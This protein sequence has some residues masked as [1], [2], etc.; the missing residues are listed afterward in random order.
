MTRGEKASHDPLEAS[1]FGGPGWSPRPTSLRQ[2]MGTIWHR[3]GLDSESAP[4]RSVLL[5]CPGDELRGI[6]DPDAVQW[7]AP[8]KAELARTQHDHMAA[9]YRDAGIAVHYVEPGEL[10]PPN[11]M[12]VADLMFMTPEGAIVGRPASTVRARE[13]RFLAR[14]L[15][16]LGVPIL[17]TVHGSGCFEGADA[18]WLDPST[19][20]IAT[21]LRTNAEGAAQ[22]AATLREL[23]VDAIIVGLPHGTM[24]MMGIL[25]F[26]D[27]NLAIAWPGRVPWA[28][29]GAL[30]EHGYEVLF[31]PMEVS[32]GMALN[33]VTLGPR[34]VLMPSGN[35]ITQAFYEQAGI[36]CRSVD[37]SE[38]IKAAGGVACMTGVLE[39]G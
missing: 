39:R 16:T 24:H 18:A 35:P 34:S 37:I 30:R 22:V 9:A 8:I 20:M 33:F 29:V 6:Q 21:G 2:E 13:E 28:A 5:H 10:P 4:L 26:A 38:L 17:R 32:P 31:L 15:A 3:C 27:R 36:K 23:G 1:A 14:R 19:V 7:L 12:F 11:M 25:R